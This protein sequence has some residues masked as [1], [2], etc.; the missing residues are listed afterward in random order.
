MFRI[1]KI[2]IFTL[3]P[4]TKLSTQLTKASWRI[5]S[6]N[7]FWYHLEMKYLHL[8]KQRL[9]EGFSI[10]SKPRYASSTQAAPRIRSRHWRKE[11]WHSTTWTWIGFY[12]CQSRR[13]TTR[14]S[15]P[16]PLWIEWRPWRIWNGL[17]TRS[18]IR[19]H[20]FKDT[21][22][23]QF[24]A[25]VC[26]PFLLHSC[27]TLLGNSGSDFDIQW[28]QHTVLHDQDT[29]KPPVQNKPDQLLKSYE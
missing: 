4:I 20:M 5:I 23:D 25:I 14:N 29:F 9:Q 11:R 18:R 12:S 16:W 2:G 22:T 26:H 7:Q 3:T 17:R 15:S 28:G 6:F 24:L 19:F 27:S 1:L 10:Y 8:Q 21:G 13:R